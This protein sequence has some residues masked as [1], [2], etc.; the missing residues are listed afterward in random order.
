M[1]TE[2]A[3]LNVQEPFPLT[4]YHHNYKH[5]QKALLIQ[6]LFFLSNIMKTGI[7]EPIL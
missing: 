5:N 7:P 1:V 4:E 2:S 6:F 3:C